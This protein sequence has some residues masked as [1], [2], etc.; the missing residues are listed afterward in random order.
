[1]AAKAKKEATEETVDVS[2]AK[3]KRVK[4]IVL[5][6]Q[7]KIPTAIKWLDRK[8]Q[9]L[10]KQIETKTVFECYPTDGAVAFY[11]ALEEVYGFTDPQRRKSWFGSFPP[12]FVDV[13]TG[14]DTS[15]RVPV[16][17]LKV[18]D[19][20]GAFYSQWTTAKGRAKFQMTFIG[21][22][23]H[24]SDVNRIVELTKELIETK[25]IYKGKAL[26]IEFPDPRHIEG[27][28]DFE[29]D[30]MNTVD[31]DPETLIFPE[32]VDRKVK[33]SLFTPVLHTDRV[34][35]AGVPLKR[36]VLLAGPYGVGKTLTAAVLAKL[37]EDNGWAFV[38]LRKVTDLPMAIEFA[39]MYGPAVIF[40]ED[41]DEILGTS[42]RTEQVNSILNTIDGVDSKTAEIMVVL[43]TNHVEN[44]N[45]AMLRP[46][47][48]DDVITVRPPDA[49]AAIRLVKQ[50]GG[51][52][53]DPNDDFA[54]AGQRLDG[55]IP[56]V[57]REVVE[58]AKLGALA[59]SEEL[60]ITDESLAT[61]A[62]TMRDQLELLEDRAPDN[63][64][65]VEKAAATLNTG[66][67]FL[68]GLEGFQAAMGGEQPKNGAASRKAAS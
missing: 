6:E 22:K 3:D 65:D 20:E 26:R 36:G 44:I 66:L 45:R 13:K 46:G 35:A 41:I 31:T 29:P 15:V 30:F 55:M 52:L 37:C 9:E 5:P 67:S 62:D 40:A 18:P 17:E 25:S 39:K 47:R 51:D 54:E 16:G 60:I 56:A 64:S 49:E 38:Y 42:S 58:R 27:F 50:Y 23:K 1:M 57:I 61:A 43:T 59:F 63:R 10:E 14:T 53:I 2:W 21:K 19:V 24:E 33:T 8:Q 32:D 12:V 48:L 7:M 11:H 34:R 68:A 4:K 28:E